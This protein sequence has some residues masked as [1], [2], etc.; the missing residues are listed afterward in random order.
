MGGATVPAKSRP[1]LE[2][3]ELE[4]PLDGEATLKGVSALGLFRGLATF[5]QLFY[6]LEEG[7]V[8]ATGAGAN[9]AAKPKGDEV[10]P[11]ASPLPMPAP[12]SQ[13]KPENSGGGA[14]STETK[15]TQTA[16]SMTPPAD[17]TPAASGQPAGADDADKPKESGT[18]S[19][20]GK[21]SG[22]GEVNA[23]EGHD[24]NGSSSVSGG[25]A[26]GDGNADD[27]DEGGASKDDFKIE[28]MPSTKQDDKAKNAQG[29][30]IGG[31]DE[32]CE[33]EDAGTKSPYVKKPLPPKGQSGTE[34]ENCEDDAGPTVAG[35]AS[36]HSAGQRGDAKSKAN[37]GPLAECD[38]TGGKDDDCEEEEQAEGSNANEHHGQPH[39]PAGAD[40]SASASASTST[41]APQISGTA[42]NSNGKGDDCEDEH[43]RGL[44]WSTKRAEKGGGDGK[45]GEG[46]GG[47]IYA[48]FGPYKITDQ[49]AFGWRGLML[50]TSRNYFS[51]VVMKK[52]SFWIYDACTEL[53]RWS[54][55]RAYGT[56][57]ATESVKL[58]ETLLS[59]RMLG[60]QADVAAV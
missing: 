52:V 18:N 44:H 47:R 3:Y 49:P 32:D 60:R 11:Q 1:A 17:N 39:S 33:D 20:S 53:V 43:K 2:R 13:A 35:A 16:T 46:K 30:A 40:H 55:W 50:D 42:D 14:A 26:T 58:Q 19:N 8:L 56:G 12:T 4:I 48:P 45:K 36:G 24:R 34:D 6:R 59:R 25:S 51:P 5:E 28:P 38:A 21:N 7:D 29:G 27:C 41:P 22:P 23:H 54:I 15:D 10:K 9:G 31:D 57:W 37:G